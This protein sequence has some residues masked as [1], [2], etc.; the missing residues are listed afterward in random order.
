V[1]GSCFFRLPGL[2]GQFHV[3]LET[4]ASAFPSTGVLCV[5]GTPGHPGTRPAI[6]DAGAELNLFL[7][8]PGFQ[9]RQHSRTNGLARQHQLNAT[10][11]EKM[12][13]RKGSG[14]TPIR[15]YP[16]SCP[17]LELATYHPS[18]LSQDSPLRRVAT[19]TKLPG[20]TRWT[21]DADLLPDTERGSHRV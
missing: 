10:K 19:S 6:C 17:L 7:V 1:F 16:S 2:R 5:R 21:T 12:P 14:N 8:Q 9:H 15:V 3:C 4:H 20:S 18:I 11:E 13:N